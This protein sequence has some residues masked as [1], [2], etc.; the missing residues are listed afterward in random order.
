MT[1]ETNGFS[2]KLAPVQARR[3]ADRG[4]L[5]PFCPR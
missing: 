1:N 5:I 2:G 3:D 4:K